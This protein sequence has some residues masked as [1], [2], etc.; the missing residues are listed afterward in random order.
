SALEGDNVVSRSENM[1]WY[2]GATLMEHLETVEIRSAFESGEMRFPIQSVIRPNAS[3]RG[4]AGRV[5]SGT[6]RPGDFVLALPSRQQTRVQ[7]IVTFDGALEVAV[8]Q[9]SVVLQLEDE[10]D[11]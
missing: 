11:L 1:P 9:Q 8:P 4:F 7:A 3:F 2:G 5:A 10:I 6:I